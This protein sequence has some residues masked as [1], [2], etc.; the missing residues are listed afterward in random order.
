MKPTETELIKK[1]HSGEP[2]NEMGENLSS[3]R[4]PQT[5]VWT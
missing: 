1:F 2:Q 3:Q 5:L 4:K